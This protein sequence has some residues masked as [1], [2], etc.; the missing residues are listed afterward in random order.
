M[1]GIAVKLA[2]TGTGGNELTQ[3]AW[4]IHV[5]YLPIA[6]WIKSAAGA[7]VESHL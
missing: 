4:P 1:S 3:K 5:H 2:I 6:V 7:M